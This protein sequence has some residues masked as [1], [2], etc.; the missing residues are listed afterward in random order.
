MRGSMRFKGSPPFHRINLYGIP[1]T[2]S[3]HPVHPHMR[4]WIVVSRSPPP[5]QYAMARY[6]LAGGRKGTRLM[7]TALALTNHLYKHHIRR[8][9]TSH[10]PYMQILT[11]ASCSHT[12]SRRAMA[13]YSLADEW[14]G[15]HVTGTALPPI[16]HLYDDPVRQ[17]ATSHS[18]I[19]GI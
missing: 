3:G 6:S 5:S 13:R 7:D 15:T 17:L 10:T 14:K 11:M 9:A 12:P 16:N 1:Y 18:P 8:S 2:T 19:R 4:L